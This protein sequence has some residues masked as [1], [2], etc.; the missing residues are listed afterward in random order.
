MY[1]LLI[2]GTDINYVSYKSDLESKFKG[3]SIRPFIFNGPKLCNI[4]EF[5]S[6]SES[7][8]RKKFRQSINHLEVLIK[9]SSLCIGIKNDDVSFQWGNYAFARAIQLDKK[10]VIFSNYDLKKIYLFVKNSKSR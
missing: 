6:I 10:A 2:A 4:S 5:S 9:T 1:K 3:Y 7:V 8:L